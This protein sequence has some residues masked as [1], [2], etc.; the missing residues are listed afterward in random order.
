MENPNTGTWQSTACLVCG[1]NCGLE[2]QVTD[3][4]IVKVRGDKRN[5]FSQGY[6]CSKGLTVGKLVDHKQRVRTPLKRMPD[7]SFA[8]LSW[9]QAVSEIAAKLGDIVKRHG[10]EA[11]ALLGGGGQA[12][13]LDFLYA[14]GF[15]SLL[16]SRRHFHVLAQEFTQKYWVNG[17]VF[18]SEGIDYDENWHRSEVILVMGSNPWMSHGFQRSRVVIREIADDPQRT[19][20]VV[21]PR[22]HETAEK[23]DMH[24]QIRPGTDLYF[25]LAL[26]NVIVTEGLVDDAFIAEHAHGWKEAR[27]IANLVTPAEAARLCDLEEADIRAVA[28]R[29]ATA[30]SASIRNHLGICHGKHMVANCYL[31]TLLHIVTGNMCT[32]DGA[33]IPVTMFTGAGVFREEKP[34]EKPRTRVAGIPSIRGF[35][36][37]NALPEE[38][39]DAGEERVRALLVEACNPI[40]SYADAQKMTAAFK[41]LDLLVV[42][43]PTMTEAARLAHYV[44]P[45]PIGYE[46]WEAASF[47]KGHPE[48]YFHLRPP[49]LPAPPETRQ[50]CIIFYELAKTMGLDYRS[51]PAFAAL[52][53]AIE[54]GDPAPVLTLIRGL[55]AMF[56]MTRQQ[57]LREAGTISADGN[58]ADEVF[59]ELLDHP[60]GVLLCKVD[61]NRNWEQVRTA[62]QKAVLDPP[63]ILDLFH[64]LK[65][66]A[67]TDFRKNREYP[68]VLQT[69]ERTDYNANTVHRDPAWRKKQRDSYLRMHQSLA[70]ELGVANGETVHLM[71]E[72]GEALVP[73]LVTDDI[74]PGNL[75]M[76]HGYGLL[77][78]NDKTGRLEPVGTNVQELMSAQHRDSLTGI[79]LHKYIPAKVKKVGG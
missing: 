66:P 9:E 3:N 15:L 51:H 48:V 12:N 75:S 13:H 59:Q 20:I 73:A 64:G 50:E 41:Q 58:P 34:S 74:Y 42:I 27:F 18:G 4:R 25:L 10:P 63:A 14:T 70:A 22:R 55:S 54:A 61:P 30:K 38:I 71:T 24:L 21:D 8:P 40:C 37:P 56:A 19:L 23:A 47:S 26:L 6:T 7:G 65:I 35:F 78:E 36:P 28:R 69:G 33:H 5:P 49:I 72:H 45:P 17:L 62:D 77:W 79:P 53:G 16:G 60:E 29:F 32:A 31:I 43:D 46:K 76:P 1:T 68:F 57:E 67:D 39:L 2:V 52:E 44:L 11:V